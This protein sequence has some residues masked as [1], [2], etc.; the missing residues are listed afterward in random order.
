VSSRR[1]HA[2]KRAKA[3]PLGA[4]LPTCPDGCGRRV[5]Y[6]L[7]EAREWQLVDRDRSPADDAAAT[8][9]VRRDGTGRWHA[10]SLARY[11]A[12]PLEPGEHRHMPHA[13]TCPVL[14][15]RARARREAGAPVDITTARR[16]P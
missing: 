2:P 1:G 12:R 3:R 11:D 4:P 16:T 10:R 15:E 9:A 5:E 13:A 7:T 6:A 14:A 8:V